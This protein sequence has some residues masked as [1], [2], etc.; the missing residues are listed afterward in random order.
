VLSPRLKLLTH[1][2]PRSSPDGYGVLAKMKFSEKL[3]PVLGDRVQ[4]QQV[5]LNV[6]MNAIEAMSEVR[7]GP[8]ELMISTSEVESGSV[9]V[10]ISDTG[11]GLSPASLARIFQAFY[12]TKASGLGLG[13]SICRSIIEAHGGRLWATP[14]EPRGAIFCILL[15]IEE[16]SRENLESSEAEL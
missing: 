15:P 3:A 13:L 10:A 8:R 5:V 11:P 16:K 1:R 6:I 14:N 2:L 7:E 12:T 4:L 9:L